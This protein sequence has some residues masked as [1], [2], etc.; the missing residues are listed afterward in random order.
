MKGIAF[1]LLTK[2]LDVKNLGLEQ[3]TKL[4]SLRRYFCA[5]FSLKRKI[6]DFKYRP[7]KDI[8]N[9]TK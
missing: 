4:N 9:L 2:K 5:Y 1:I 8:K 6:K 7:E 3:R